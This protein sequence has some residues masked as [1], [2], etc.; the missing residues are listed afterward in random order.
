MALHR[1]GLQRVFDRRFGGQRGLDE[2]ALH[3]TELVEHPVDLA[4][5]QDDF[6]LGSL[7]DLVVVARG[8]P[9]LSRG[10]VLAHHDY[11]CL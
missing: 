4:V 2:A 1:I 5:E 6:E 11:R 9:V 3:L 7:V 10:A 8:D